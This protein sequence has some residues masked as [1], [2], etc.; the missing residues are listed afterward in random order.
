MATKWDLMKDEKTVQILDAALIEFGENGYTNTKL[1]DIAKR[2]GTSAALISKYFEKKEKLLLAVCRRDSSYISIKEDS[3]AQYPDAIFAFI[4]RT[5]KAKE[6]GRDIYKLWVTQAGATDIPDYVINEEKRDFLDSSIYEELKWAQEQGIVHE[7]DL[8]RMFCAFYKSFYSLIDACDSMGIKIP[9]K[10]LILRILEKQDGSQVGTVEFKGVSYEAKSSTDD[11]KDVVGTKAKLIG[12]LANDYDY[13]SHIVLENDEETTYRFRSDFVNTLSGWND[14]NDFKSR[15]DFTKEHVVHPDDKEDFYNRTRK[16]VIIDELERNEIYY[17][18]FRELINDEIIYY[19]A[20]FAFG[21]PEHKT[22]VAGFRS[23]NEQMRIRIE[24]QEKLSKDFNILN[25]LVSE[26]SSVGYIDAESGILTP[27]A[28]QKE[29]ESLFSNGIVDVNYEETYKYYVDTLV[30]SADKDKLI[31]NGSIE[32]IKKKLRNTKSFSMTYRVMR[33]GILNY[34]EVKFV[35][36]NAINEECTAFAIAFADRDEDVVGNY[37]KDKLEDEYELIYIVDIENNIYRPYKIPSDDALYDN[38]A[39]IWSDLYSNLMDVCSSDTAGNVAFIENRETLSKSLK[40]LNKKE[41]VYKRQ[42][43]EDDLWRRAV[44]YVIERRNNEPSSI[45]LTVSALD[46]DSAEKEDLNIKIAKQKEELEISHRKISRAK[47][48]AEKMVELRTAELHD[49]NLELLRMNE[50]I[51]D[52]LGEIVE[53]R[54]EESGEHI[55][56]VK[57]YTNI[58]AKQ[59]M[60]DY[61]EY[62]LDDYSVGVITSAAALHDVGKIAIPDSILLKPGKLTP[63]EF[64]VMKSHS[65]EGCRIINRLENFWDKE[66]LRVS[67]EIC[68]HHHEKWNGKGYPDGLCGDD[69]PISAQIVSIADIFDAL[70]M[71]RCYKAAYPS[72]KAF[73]MIENGECGEFSEKILSCLKKVKDEYTRQAS[74]S[75]MIYCADEKGGNDSTTVNVMLDSNMD[76]M[77]TSLAI[78]F[79]AVHMVDVDKDLIRDIQIKGSYGR[80]IS[81]SAKEPSYR[82]R[83]AEDIEKIVAPEDKFRVAKAFDA[84][85][86]YERLQKED[87]FDVTFRVIDKDSKA[88]YNRARFGRAEKEKGRKFIIGIKNYDDDMIKNES[89]FRNDYAGMTVMIV[90][91]DSFSRELV[92]ELLAEPGIVTV[93]AQNGDQAINI[94]NS[95]EKIDL[96][97]M[98]IVMPGLNGIDT[99]KA[100]REL[101]SEVLKSIPIIGLSANSTDEQAEEIM[102]VGANDCLTKPLVLSEFFK[103]VFH[104]FAT[105]DTGRKIDIAETTRAIT[106][107]PLTHVKNVT[108]YTDIVAEMTDL[109]RTK[110]NVQFGIV[111]CDVDYLK[112]END[113]YGHDIGDMYIQNSCRIICEVFRHSPVY[114]IGGDEFAVVL[115]GTDYYNSATL[116]NEMR[117]RV[118]FASRIVDSRHGKASFSSGIAI[119]DKKID[120]TMSD[121]IRRAYKQMMVNRKEKATKL[122]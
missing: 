49:R 3:S 6:E 43:A 98:D 10:K 9:S 41:F 8:W 32:S 86:V 58:L 19:Q 73:E 65:A 57:G 17:V 15:L 100:I 45:L 27:Y 93:E 11:E 31:K 38:E 60:K 35:K 70:T 84:E 68:R 74:A 34:C 94:L 69:I 20:K 56:R 62:G 71:K 75:T 55:Q 24:Q 112:E 90:D 29:I 87:S 72:E 96:I 89:E 25:A 22:I 48:E 91:D 37:I 110:E 82:K 108:A 102:I 121:M 92:A 67:M 111:M 83:C 2:A 51:I 103:S 4:D 95:G 16:D 77:V 44:V 78:D 122:S 5:I 13:I 104:C 39:H 66:Y 118:E 64:E 59:V 14:I 88:T 1:S 30:Y 113:K 117:D 101:D 7:G 76:S 23:I 26:F 36:V 119:Y 116:M 105:T 53:G 99:T 21:D 12:E 50:G 18:N 42:D 115:Q 85:R 46:K 107:D 40:K 97:L 54:D 81:V 80:K 33:D 114:R 106:T 79:D 109:I 61:P 28:V 52:L 120:F 63:E 47:D